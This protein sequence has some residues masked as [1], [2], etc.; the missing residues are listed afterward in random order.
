MRVG[1]NGPRW[2][3]VDLSALETD[4]TGEGGDLRSLTCGVPAGSWLL[5]AP[6]HPLLGR[7]V[8][9]HSNGEPFKPVEGVGCRVGGND[10]AE[11][12]TQ[13]RVLTDLSG[14]FVY[15]RRPGN[16]MTKKSLDSHSVTG[17]EVPTPPSGQ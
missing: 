8:R 6:S 14:R 1:V 5:P 13:A 9:N 16:G 4:T 17:V 12:G 15:G 10:R 11:E 7:R 3:P 2:A